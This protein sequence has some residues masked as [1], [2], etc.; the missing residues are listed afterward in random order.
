MN[1]ATL[2][3]LLA[4]SVS[5]S[6]SNAAIIVNSHSF[7][8][9]TTGAISTA[10]AADWGYVS[11]SSG[12]FDSNLTGAGLSYN[13]TPYGSLTRDTGVSITTVSGVSSIGTVTLTEGTT[14]SNTVTAQSSTSNFTFNGN[15]SYGSYGSF[16][17]TEQDV[18]TMGFNNLGV[19]QFNI[20]LYMAHEQSN[21]VFDMDVSGTGL[22]GFTTTS[23]QIGT[24]GSTVA[25][26]GTNGSSF[27]YDITITTTDAS[28]DLSLTFGS[29]SGS[30]GT[31][32][33]SGYTVTQI[34]EPSTALMGGLGLLVLFRRRR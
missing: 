15:T 2:L 3:P 1:H 22:A 9:V 21:R 26:I 25:G 8:G 30:T 24:L 20:R 16:A 32:I 13:N 12:F 31:A 6:I 11:V 14:S 19:G 10:G 7:N 4:L 23:A 34:P 18:W 28:D 33:F 5:S 27:I 29:V 17:S